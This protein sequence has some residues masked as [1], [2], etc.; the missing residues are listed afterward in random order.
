[1]TS[2]NKKGLIKVTFQN[3]KKLPEDSFKSCIIPYVLQGV[4]IIDKHF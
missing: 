4:N 2:K 3:K 1:M